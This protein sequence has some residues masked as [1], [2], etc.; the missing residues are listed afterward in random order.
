MTER[1][2]RGRAPAPSI[3]YHGA[4]PSDQT[5]RALARPLVALLAVIGLGGR[6]EA[7]S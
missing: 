6:G 7:Q 3:R 4:M 1:S 5:D 2:R